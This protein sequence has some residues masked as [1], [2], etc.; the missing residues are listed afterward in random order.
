M[1]VSAGI[2]AGVLAAVTAG[3]AS[4]A[5]LTASP[6]NSNKSLFTIT[7][8]DQNN[9]GLFDIGDPFTFSGVTFNFGLDDPQ[10]FAGILG[11]PEIAGI[12]APSAPADF[13]DTL[14]E[15]IGTASWRFSAAS[16]PFGDGGVG[17][18]TY[19]LTGLTDPAVVPLPAGLPLLLAAIGALALLRRRPAAA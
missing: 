2:L 3:Q 15:W 9:N 6:F 10:D 8:T 16:G 18:W 7:F 12:S 14:E 17:E 11:I 4:A 5:V 13:G 19:E 1:K